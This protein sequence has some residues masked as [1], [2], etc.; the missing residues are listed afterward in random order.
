MNIKNDDEEQMKYLVE[1]KAKKEFKRKLRM[2]RID[3]FLQILK[4][5]RFK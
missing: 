1:W 4:K 5:R 2:Q 3:N